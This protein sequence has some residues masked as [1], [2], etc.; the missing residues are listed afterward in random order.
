MIALLAYAAWAAPTLALAAFNP[1]TTN[2][3]VA[4]LAVVALIMEGEGVQSQS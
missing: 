4:A 2:A 1:V 3:A